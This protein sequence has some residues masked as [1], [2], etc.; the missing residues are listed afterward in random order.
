MPLDFKPRQ[1]LEVIPESIDSNFKGEIILLLKIGLNGKMIDYKIVS[2]TIQIE[3]ALQNAINAAKKS[4]W[5]AGKIGNK[6]VE[7][8][9][10]KIYKF[11]M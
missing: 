9:I 4:L 2:N 1:I 5:E 11:N 6:P 3:I 7:Y 10:E 8:W